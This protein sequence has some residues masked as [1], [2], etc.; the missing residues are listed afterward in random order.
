MLNT[1]KK[2]DWVEIPIS[3]MA[4]A[5]A[6][7]EN[8][9]GLKKEWE[10]P[11]WTGFHIGGTLFS[12]ALSG[13]KGCKEGSKICKGCSPCIFRFSASKNK[14][15]KNVFTVTALISFRVENLDETYKDLKEKGVEF[16]TEPK[17]QAWGGRTAL[18][19]DPDENIIVLS[20]GK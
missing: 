20:E 12:I 2:I 16:I 10:G 11:D 4:R 18:M 6:F 1:S 3:D 17:K 5:K 14:Q 9:I 15:E 13:T 8:V 19:L 7:Y